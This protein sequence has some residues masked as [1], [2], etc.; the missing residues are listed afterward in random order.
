M[1]QDKAEYAVCQPPWAIDIPSMAC[2]GLTCMYNI[3]ITDD[4]CMIQMI[5]D[6]ELVLQI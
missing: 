3:C 1:H 2:L 6:I 4:E 5:V